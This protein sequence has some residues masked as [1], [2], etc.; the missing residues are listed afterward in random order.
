VRDRDALTAAYIVCK[1]PGR[2]R[3]AQDIGVRAASSE[4]IVVIVWLASYPRSGNTLLRTI[5]RQ[6]FH[7]KSYSLYDDKLD[8]GSA[9]EVR[10]IVGH[11]SLPTEWDEFYEAKRESPDLVFVKT[12]DRPID[13]GPAIYIVR[14]GRSAIV[15]W[16]NM[17]VS[18]RKRTDISI[19]DIIVGDG[20]VY[21]DWSSHIGNWGPSERPATL[22]LRY[23]DLLARTP[24]AL[25]KIAGFITKPQ[26]APWID[27]FS[28]LH[29]L[30]PEFFHRGSDEA[31][32]DQ[33]SEEETALFWKTHG[34]C[35]RDF[36]FAP[37]PFGQS[38]Q[39]GI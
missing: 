4:I 39:S 16:Y 34:A 7:L 38:A 32:F 18:F 12:H 27:R 9:S 13:S 8:L 23:D 19:S 35:M 14:D 31:N 30:M 6:A 37:A 15:S 10:D 26:C 5:L 25:E 21:G 1:A 36:G 29:S 24:A 33:M 28:V 3:V 22:L 17:L 20:V 2:R 11:E